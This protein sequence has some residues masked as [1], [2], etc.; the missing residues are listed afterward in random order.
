MYPI[1]RG[2]FVNFI[3]FEFHPHEEG[4]HLGDPWVTEVDPSYVQ[5]LFHGW[6]KDVSELTQV[7][8]GPSMTHF[9]KR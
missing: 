3:V 5:N 4:R 2:R 6:E 9:Q 8:A 7:S 1:S